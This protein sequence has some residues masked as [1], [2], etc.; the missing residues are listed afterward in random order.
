[1]PALYGFNEFELQDDERE[2][3]RVWFGDLVHTWPTYSPLM[4]WARDGTFNFAFSYAAEALSTPGSKG[5]QWRIVDGLT[6]LGVIEPKPEEIPER[7]KRFREKI[8][9][10]M[11]NWDEM[12]NSFV[13]EWV[14]IVKPFKEFDVEGAN[15]CELFNCWEEYL[16]LVWRRMW[17]E[18]FKWMEPA[19]M[20]FLEFQRVCPEVTGVTP[21]DALFKKVLAGFDN[22][23]LRF[24]RELWHLGDRAK[25]LGLEQLFL[26]IEDAEELL[27]KLEETEAGRKWLQEYRTF[28]NIHGWRCNRPEEWLYNPSW[29]EKPSLGIPMIKQAMGKGGVFAVDK[30]FERLKAEREEAEKELLSRVPIE[31]REWFEKLMRCAQRSGVFSEDHNYY[32]DMVTMALGRRLTREMGKR[33]TK[34]GALDDPDDIYFLHPDEIRKGATPMERANLR[35]YAKK[36]REEWEQACK[37]Q[38]KPFIGDISAAPDLAMKECHIPI[39]SAVPIVVPE[40][41]AD[42]YGTASVPGVVEG[43]ARVIPDEK[44]MH[45]LQ[46]GE[47]LVAATTMSTWTPLFSIAKAVVTDGGGALSHAVIV[48]REYGLPVVAGTLEATRKIRTGMRIRVDGDRNAVYILE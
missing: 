37:L 39:V 29:I 46:A 43:I 4:A 35:P 34:A 44:S 2:N 7:E 21:Q 15:N 25:E 23:I 31:Q 38:P 28:L 45:E 33:F 8:V 11:E 3:Y 12:W 17:L 18:H 36:R 20:L 47:I 13:A 30:E 48:G 1:M 42:L 32:L 24:N 9:P 6:Y 22:V 41:K 26:T 16:F 40:L 5:L 19:Y 10:Y 14:A 27:S